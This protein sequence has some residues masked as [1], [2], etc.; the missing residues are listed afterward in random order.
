MSLEIKD[1][2]LTFPDG[3]NRITAV[4]KASMKV[5]PGELAVITGPSGS[6]KSSLLAAT[7]LLITTDNGEIFLDDKEVSKFND[8]EKTEIRGKKMGM[9][10]QSPNLI[11]SITVLEQ[12]LLVNKIAKVPQDKNYAMELLKEVGMDDQAHKLPAQLSG[13]QQQRVNI[14][15]ALMN[16]T[17]LLIVDEPTSALD[18]K[19]SK[20][21]VELIKRLTA[22]KKTATLMVTHNEA[23]LKYA[24]SSYQMLD[25]VLTNV[26]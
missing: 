9:I 4:D 10:F 19:K 21:I 6:G 1:L 2:T 14:A 5:A 23:D 20:E 13:G 26:N 15:R 8:A 12:L 17:S 25:G 3:D 22:E 24:D 16:N 11:P 18:S 7:A